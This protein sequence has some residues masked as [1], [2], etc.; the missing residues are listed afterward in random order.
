MERANRGDDPGHRRMDACLDE[1]LKEYFPAS[2]P[3]SS[4]PGRD[5]SDGDDR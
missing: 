2:D 5:P 3:P 4:W 1:V